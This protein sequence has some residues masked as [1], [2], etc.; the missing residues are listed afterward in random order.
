MPVFD[1]HVHVFPDAIAARAVAH[2]AA[3]AGNLP[4]AY[5]GSRAG[6]EACLRA[7][8]I[9]GALNCPIATRPEQ[10]ESI[11]RWAADQN[12]WPM[13]SLGT[14]HPRYAEPVAELERV[15]GAGLPGIKMHPEYQEFG[16]RDAALQPIWECCQEL[17]LLVLLH[18]GE[19]I[20]FPPPC[21]VRPCDLRWLV[22]RYPRLRVIAAHFGGW[23]L[24]DE[25]ERDLIGAPL[26]LDLS[27]LSDYLPAARLVGLARRH[28]IG[29]VLFA[30]DAP[31]RNPGADLAAC[32]ALPFTAAEQGAIL[33]DNAAR[34]LS[35]PA[36]AAS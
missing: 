17:D 24:W 36:S 29:R 33:W 1:C 8:G 35:L 15:R 34:L 6:L 20:A 13:L 5:D 23:R 21:R 14:M 31:W 30:T 16:V 22:E 10:V 28:G 7:A 25:V 27:F 2:I 9:D 12:R 32:R 18:P 19:D 3:A 4:V 26:F 11:N